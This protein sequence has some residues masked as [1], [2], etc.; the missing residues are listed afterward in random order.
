MAGEGMTFRQMLDRLEE[1]TQTLEREDLEL[2]EGLE[3]FEEGIKLLKESRKKLADARGKVEM[4]L[5]SID[6]GVVREELAFGEKNE[7][8]I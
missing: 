2:E 8:L 3:L 5:G 4:L 6:E 1:I 7:D